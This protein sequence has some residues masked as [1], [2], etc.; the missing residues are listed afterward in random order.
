MISLIVFP[1]SGFHEQVNSCDYGLGSSVF[2][3]DYSRAERI[4]AGIRA[5]MCN[6][7]DFGINYL[8]QAL[9]FGGVKV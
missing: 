6:I 8:C 9:P 1:I 3:L 4:A 7:N 2:S 5:G